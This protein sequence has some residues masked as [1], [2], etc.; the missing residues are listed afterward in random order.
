MHNENVHRDR[1]SLKGTSEETLN[2]VK[3]SIEILSIINIF[4]LHVSDVTNLQWRLGGRGVYRI[5]NRHGAE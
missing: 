2:V 3:P 5:M 1:N 4:V